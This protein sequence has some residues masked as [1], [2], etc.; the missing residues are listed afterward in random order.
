[1]KKY[2]E[3]LYIE[4]EKLNTQ[5][6]IKALEK[7]SP[8]AVL[9]DVGCWDGEA[10]KDW[11]FAS[12]P[13]KIIGIESANVPEVIKKAEAL[14]I[15]VKNIQADAEHWPIEDNSVD[16]V[17]SNQVVEHLTNLD[18]FFSEAQRVLKPGGY[19]VTS[20]NNLSSFHNIVSLVLG[21]APFDLTNSSSKV[22]G[23]GNP[24]ALHKNERDPRGA[25]WTHKCVYT[26]RWLKDWQAIYGLEFVESYG[27]GLYPF[28]STFGSI[29]KLYSAFITVVC[30]KK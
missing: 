14:N 7:N 18:H 9:L 6:V 4:A 23:I 5:N 27:A 13:E 26:V 19:I 10:T 24:F 2:L 8:H 12:K 22:S 25:T 15:Q 30:R 3:K 11:I 29:L 28:P 16:C 1:M 17:V 21:F 20:T